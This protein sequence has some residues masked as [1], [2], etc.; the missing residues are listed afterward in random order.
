M[1]WFASPP[2]HS[3]VIALVF[4]FIKL[5]MHDFLNMF[6]TC[7]HVCVCTVYDMCA[8]C[9]Q[10]MFT[11]V[12][13][14]AIYIYIRCIIYQCKFRDIHR[15]TIYIL[16]YISYVHRYIPGFMGI[17]APKPLSRLSRSGFCRGADDKFFGPKAEMSSG[18]HGQRGIFC[19]GH[20]GFTLW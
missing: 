14:Y 16:I 1:K 10:Q 6:F 8:F 5:P 9:M 3:S 7:T 19:G 18:L 11:H 15:Y 20:H 2:C 12:N 13:I 17:S 4:W